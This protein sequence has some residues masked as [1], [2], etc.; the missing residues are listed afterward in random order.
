MTRRRRAWLIVALLISPFLIYLILLIPEPG[1]HPPLSSDRQAFTWNR[2]AYWSYLEEQF[3]NAR[4]AESLALADSI[5]ARSSR[6][7]ALLDSLQGTSLDADAPILDRLE[8]A[9]FELTPWL[10]ARPDHPDHFISQQVQLREIIKNQS[11]FWDLGSVTSRDRLYRLLYGSRIAL[12]EVM[13]QAVPASVPALVPASGEPSRTPQGELLGITVHSGDIVV[14][15]GGAPTSALIARGSDYPGN[16][17]HVTLVHID[18]ASGQ[19]SIVE[20]HIERGVAIATPD[21]YLRDTKL[22]VMALRLRA[23][24]PALAADPMLPHRAA[25]IALERA[26]SEHIPYDFAMDFSDDSRLFCSEVAS[27]P[28][29]ELGISLW[30]GTSHISSAGVKAWLVSVSGTSKRRSHPTWNTILNSRWWPNGAT[31]TYS[32]RIISTTPWWT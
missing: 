11:R 5:R 4:A 29:A 6:L 28:Y 9:V 14:S 13:L 7:D 26:Y 16:F 1:Y 21:E 19:I 30:M 3:R 15:R 2:D 20:A 23:D 12:E 25:T 18:S 17:S 22:R 31:R 8:T 32:G 10:A 27:S 24:H